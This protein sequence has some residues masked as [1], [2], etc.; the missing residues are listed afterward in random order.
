MYFFFNKGNTV[1][2]SLNLWGLP[3]I[4][5]YRIILLAVLGWKRSLA[6]PE[7]QL[8]MYY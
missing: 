7:D 6:G 1:L 8:D 5:Y 3:E 4:F 2:P